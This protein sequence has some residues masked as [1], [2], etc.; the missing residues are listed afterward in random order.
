MMESTHKLQITIS[1]LILIIAI[2]SFFFGPGIII[3]YMS[4]GVPPSALVT[5]ETPSSTSPQNSTEKNLIVGKWTKNPGTNSNEDKAEANLI[6]NWTFYPDG[7]F[8]EIHATTDKDSPPIYDH[9]TWVYL[10]NTSYL[11]TMEGLEMHIVLTGNVLTNEDDQCTF[12]RI[13]P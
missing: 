4:N 7:T 3:R 12:H 5:Q 9:G 8:A 10:G 11:I 2:A 6:E 13:I 1:A